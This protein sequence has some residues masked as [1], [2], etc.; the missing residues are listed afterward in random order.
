MLGGE[1]QGHSGPHVS[2]S[3]PCPP[4]C[5]CS[6][7]SQP[8]SPSAPQHLLPPLHPALLS[9]FRGQR[10]EHSPRQVALPCFNFLISGWLFELA[11]HIKQN[12]RCWCPSPGEAGT[13]GLPALGGSGNPAPPPP[14]VPCS[15]CH[16]HS[17]G[18]LISQAHLRGPE[19]P[20]HP[21]AGP[22]PGHSPSR[23]ALPFLP[24]L[25]ALRPGSGA[26]SSRKL[27]HCAP[28][29]GLWAA[30]ADASHGE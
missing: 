21:S 24:T 26:P 2:S 27:N 6:F 30:H 29:L 11:S 5:F 19:N 23:N 10:W 8:L 28:Q 1:A 25:F 9:K 13:L 7:R 4:T 14:P 22:P 17:L 15:T 3:G 20:G 16:G 18:A 12:P